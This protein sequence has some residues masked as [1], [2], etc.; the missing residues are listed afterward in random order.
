[1]TVPEVSHGNPVTLLS[2]ATHTSGLPRLI[3]GQAPAAQLRSLGR[4]GLPAG[5][6]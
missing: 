2:L 5:A 3:P 6:G 4:T 1:M